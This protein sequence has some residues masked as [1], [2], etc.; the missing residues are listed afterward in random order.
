MTE[1]WWC[2]SEI[3]LGTKS[4]STEI[5][6]APVETGIDCLQPAKENSLEAWWKTWLFI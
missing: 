6:F 2:L 4:A 3:L 5:N 1:W